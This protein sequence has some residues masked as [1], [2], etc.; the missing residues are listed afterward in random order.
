MTREALAK[1][2]QSRAQTTLHSCC[3]DWM[4]WA[5]WQAH[6]I[7][8][9]R[10]AFPHSKDSSRFETFT[11]QAWSAPPGPPPIASMGASSPGTQAC[12]V[13]LGPGPLTLEWRTCRCLWGQLQRHRLSK[14]TVLSLMHC[15]GRSGFWY[16]CLYHELPL[17]EVTVFLYISKLLV[18]EWLKLHLCTLCPSCLRHYELHR[19]Y[20]QRC[21][22][23]GSFSLISAYIHQ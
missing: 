20:T 14:K 1:S 2:P 9:M 13:C 15:T 22:Y 7:Q 18:K 8:G 5:A 19:L 6:R 21:Y 12:L 16:I 17:L 4:A 10:K 23:S 11:K 3:W